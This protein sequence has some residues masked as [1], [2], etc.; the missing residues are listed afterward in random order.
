MALIE[1][2]HAKFVEENRPGFFKRNL[3]FLKICRSF[4]LIPFKLNNTYI[5]FTKW[6]KSNRFRTAV[7]LGALQRLHP[8]KPFTAN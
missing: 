2:L 8:V 1:K 3:V 4:G 5:V 7:R 6:E